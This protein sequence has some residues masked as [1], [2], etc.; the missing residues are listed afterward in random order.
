MKQTYILAHSTARQRASAACHDA[1]EGYAVTISPPKRS[2]A[3]NAML[4]AMLTTISNQIDW[5]GKKRDV[6]TW[7]RLMVAAWCRIKGEQ[8]EM[9]PALDG[10]GFDIVYAKTSELDKSDC[11]D[12]ITFVQ[13]WAAEH[14][15]ELNEP[16]YA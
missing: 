15:I 8:V 10:H 11:A 6:E 5:A 16:E 7:K 4:H 13:A 12:L 9:L 2:L 1:P 3:E 14:D